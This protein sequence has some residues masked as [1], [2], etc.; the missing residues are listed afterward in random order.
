MPNKN[1]A[2]HKRPKN[3][4]TTHNEG[5]NRERCGVPLPCLSWNTGPSA[6]DALD[7]EGDETVL[8]SPARKACTRGGAPI[9]AMVAA[10]CTMAASAAKDFCALTF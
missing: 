9:P 1:V 2:S 10:L 8:G 5:E 6:G 3:L 7:G 4:P